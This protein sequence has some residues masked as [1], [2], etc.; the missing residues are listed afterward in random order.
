M[1]MTEVSPEQLVQLRSKMN[2]SQQEMADLIG[3]SQRAYSRWELN[4]SQPKA[5]S[6]IRILDIIEENL[7]ALPKQST[8]KLDLGIPLIPISAMAGIGLSQGIQIT[9]DDIDNSYFIPDFKGADFMIRVKGD[10]MYPRYNSGDIVACKKLNIRDIFFQWNKVYILDTDQGAILKRISKASDQD[11][12][13]VVS[14]NE[15]YAP[16]ELK[17]SQ[18]H[19]VAI[20]VGVIRPE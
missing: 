17:L 6:L 5:G 11:K 3:V 14:D 20:V 7:D 13:L 15:A 1:K 8:N 4:Q 12:V 16:F 2:L 19:G 18:I 9:K 10:S